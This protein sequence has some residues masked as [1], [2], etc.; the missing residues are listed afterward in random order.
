[1][2]IADGEDMKRRHCGYVKADCI[3]SPC[4]LINI[5]ENIWKAVNFRKV[6]QRKSRKYCVL[7]IS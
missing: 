5:S 3:E 2:Q 6:E 7:N 4:T 1:M